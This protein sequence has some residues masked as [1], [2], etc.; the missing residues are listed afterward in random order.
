ME[1]AFGI[2]L[3]Q[4]LNDTDRETILRLFE[5]KNYF[6]L[7]AAVFLFPM[8]DFFNVWV[9]YDGDPLVKIKKPLNNIRYGIQ[10]DFPCGVT[11]G[12]RIKCSLR[13]G[14]FAAITISR[15]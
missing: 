3:R 6:T 2:V 4:R 14:I 10:V 12:R 13:A 7:A 9:L 1:R 5:I 15:S 8:K 11:Q